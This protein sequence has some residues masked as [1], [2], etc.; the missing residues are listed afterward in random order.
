MLGSL[1]SG[2]GVALYIW[3]D[4]TE[5]GCS[6]PVSFNPRPIPLL[7]FSTKIRVID[8]LIQCSLDDVPVDRG[9]SHCTNMVGRGGLEGLYP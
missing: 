4:M 1:I 5:S 3:I 2:L 8:P 7:V 6:V 9:S